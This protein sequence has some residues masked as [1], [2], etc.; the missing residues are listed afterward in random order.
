MTS[1]PAQ[2]RSE[3]LILDD[4]APQM[5][6]LCDTLRE[7]GYGAT[8]FT[9]ARKALAELRVRKFDL[10]LTDLMMPEMDG[11]TVLRSA[12]EID[13]QLVGVM[14]TGHAT[15][16]TAVEAMK[17]GALDYILKPFKLS[18]ILP[19][20]ARALAV[21]RLRCENEDLQNRI[22]ART[23][24][25]EASNKE[26]EAFSYSV[27][28]DLR[29]PLRAITA[30][31]EILVSDH[32]ASLS[33]DARTIADRVLVNSQRMARLIEDLL[34]FSRFTRQSLT[35][36][37][38]D[39][40]RLVN[41]VL[42]ELRKSGDTRPVTVE[43]GALPPC[44]G[45][46]SL[47]RQVWINLLSNAFKFTRHQPEPRVEIGCREEADKIVYFVRDNGAGF[48][49]K[50]AG[51]LFGVFQRLHRADEF[52]GTGIGLSIVHRIVQR[53]GGR[54]WAEAEEGKGA[55]FFFS[56]PAAASDSGPEIAS[57]QSDAQPGT[58]VA[59]A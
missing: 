23:A 12:L 15:V 8:G 24:E 38:V 31:S 56:L 37:P 46:H 4:E 44:Q 48:D 25:L 17:A 3:L 20:L 21:R 54:I 18:A 29:A 58:S 53:H 27:S 34:A 43:I 36:R 19:V 10:L 26:L 13:P 50:F 41:E 33:P 52:E 55:T 57:D 6:A 11:I 47:L 2:G 35:R 42:D 39:M 7:Q 30:F 16:D 1:T 32:G 28:H 5:K 40:A 59:N 51:R 45:D 22:R 14:M 9:E 49:M